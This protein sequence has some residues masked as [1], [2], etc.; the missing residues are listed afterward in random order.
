MNENEIKNLFYYCPCSGHLYWKRRPQSDFFSIG[1][2]RTWNTRFANKPAGYKSQST[3]NKNTYIK[4]QYKGK[5]FYAHRIIASMELGIPE[6]M[7]VDH[8]NG[9]GCDNRL[10]NLRVVSSSENSMNLRYSP[11]NKTGCFGVVKDKR[12]GKWLAQIKKGRKNRWLGLF[13][14]FEDAKKA[15]IDAE[16]KLGF[17]PSHGLLLRAKQ[18]VCFDTE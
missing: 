9:D 18:V 4:V 6:G 15:R 10:L 1:S 11:R 7:E 12:S 16:Q 13:D 2:F 8:I 3:K 17:G 14:K 5:N